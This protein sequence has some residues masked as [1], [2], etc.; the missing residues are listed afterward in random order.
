[1][2]TILS[3]SSRPRAARV[4]YTLFQKVCKRQD[5]KYKFLSRIQT[6]KRVIIRFKRHMEARAKFVK[7]F[8]K[9]WNNYLT[10]KIQEDFRTSN[11]SRFT[12][13][14]VNTPA[15]VVER[16][17]WLFFDKSIQANTIRVMPTRKDWFTPYFLKE[18]TTQR[19]SLFLSDG[20][21]SPRKE[22]QIDM[23]NVS[24]LNNSMNFT[25]KISRQATR[26]LEKKN[27]RMLGPIL[28]DLGTDQQASASQPSKSVPKKLNLQSNRPKSSKKTTT[29]NSS[30]RKLGEG[31]SSIPD[32]QL[33]VRQPTQG[34]DQDLSLADVGVSS[35]RR[36][37][38]QSG[39][40]R[41]N[42]VSK[43]D[44]PRGKSSLQRQGSISKEK[45][46]KKPKRFV[47]GLIGS[48][49]DEDQ[50]IV[51]PKAKLTRCLLAVK[52]ACRWFLIIERSKYPKKWI[53]RKLQKK[54]SQMLTV[55][56]DL[57]DS[58]FEVCV[59]LL[60]KHNSANFLQYKGTL[61]LDRSF[62]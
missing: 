21:E 26:V 55:V 57:K 20:Q 38:E 61:E 46:K 30:K 19:P 24:L 59:S 41:A 22:R 32:Q 29:T 28:Q 9:K 14:F 17:A 12:R 7:D 16:L 23:L 45:T 62:S 44:S 53:A 43:V 54:P 39:L 33:P 13:L 8:K 58:D 36:R 31:R 15:S 5:V 40:S 34:S 2:S 50:E 6:M 52:A 37:D 56:C 1:M 10:D 49:G 42:S 27:T 25:N 11:Y 18:F 47:L 4:V 3:T 35:S 60:H 51:T 48:G